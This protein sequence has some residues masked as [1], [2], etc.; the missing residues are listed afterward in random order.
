[1]D[2]KRMLAGV[3]LR[4]T[5]LFPIWVMTLD[6]DDLIDRD[7][8]SYMGQVMT[9][10]HT[11]FILTGGYIFSTKSGALTV[12]KGFHRKSGS[13]CVF[14]V[15]RGDLPLNLDDWNC[16]YS[17]A[18]QEQTSSALRKAGYRVKRITWPAGL[19]VQGHSESISQ[20]SRTR[21]DKQSQIKSWPW[22]KRLKR[23]ISKTVWKMYLSKS[24]KVISHEEKE[25]ILVRFG[26]IGSD[27][28]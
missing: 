14:K 10:S 17:I 18:I 9:S 11:G 7:L 15:D 20:D 24:N 22:R 16:R 21:Q 27:L 25:E 23:K 19:Y 8:V 28:T 1:M 2:N 3:H 5:A 4:A 12:T 13:R 6:A 26:V